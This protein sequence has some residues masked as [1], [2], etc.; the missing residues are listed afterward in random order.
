MKRVGNLFGQ[1]IDVKN[2]LAAHNNAKKGKRNYA[3]VKRF[4]ERPYHYARNI[5]RSLINKSYIPSP[6][7][8][9][10]I[11]DRGKPR[12]ILKTSYYPDRI[13]HHAL[14]QV[15]Q[16]I[17]ESTYIKDTYQSI[18]GR[19]THKAI[20]RIKMWLKDERSTRYCLKIDIRKFYPNVDNEILKAMFRKKIK[21][22]DTLHLLDTVVDSSKG[23][24]IGNYTS[25]TFA[26]Y[27][28]SFFDHFVKEDLGSKLYIRYADD[29]VVFG[30]SKEE[31]HAKL[32]A[33][34]AYL[35]TLK[36][37]IKGN[38][39]VFETR[40]RG[41]D[42]LGYRLFGHYTLLRKKMVTKIKRAVLKP[43]KTLS[44]ISRVMSYFGWMKTAN[45]YNLLRV[46]LTRSLRD[47][48]RAV[49]KRLHIKN[50]FR[51]FCIA[52]KRSSKFLQL[53]LF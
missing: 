28:L 8:S 18:K 19:G 3:E 29:I 49:V 9:M 10:H 37:E 16:P 21:C 24:P 7:V 45:A 50:P 36:L 27:Y 14:M 46:L 35:D 1:I 47:K 15:V 4:E 38:W 12:E 34:R 32:K 41:L 2:I 11:S 43:V 48:V 31:L 13:I 23:L 42:F 17:F 26:N 53:T 5:R 25:Q 30:E 39:Q 20:E 6:Y 44:D 33:M 51:N 52:P 40:G 22:E